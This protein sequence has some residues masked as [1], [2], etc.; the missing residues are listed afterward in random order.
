M[1]NHLRIATMKYINDLFRKFFCTQRQRQRQKKTQHVLYL[2]KASALRISNMILR[3]GQSAASAHQQQHQRIS[4]I[5]KISKISMISKKLES[6]KVIGA[7]YIS[8]VVFETA[9]IL[10]ASEGL[11]L[12]F[13]TSLKGL[14]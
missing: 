4:R 8:D 10:L 11:F 3:G 13:G 1:E 7:T 12:L 2:R 5:C 9:L 6:Q 14:G